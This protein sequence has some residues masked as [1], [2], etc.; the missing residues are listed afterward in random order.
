[1]TPKQKAM[2]ALATLP[3]DVSYHDLEEEVRILSALEE[4]EDDIRNGRVVTHEEAKRRLAQWTS[5]S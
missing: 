5:S 4:A 1:M 3:E 2:L